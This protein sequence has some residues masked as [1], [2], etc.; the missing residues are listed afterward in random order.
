M[1]HT[2]GASI[3]DPKL[4]GLIPRITEQ[5]F[6]TIVASPST[7][8]YLVKV[9]YMEIYMVRRSPRVDPRHADAV[10]RN[11]YEICSLV[12]AA[13]WAYAGTCLTFRR[14]A[15]NDNLPIHEDKARGVYVKNLSDYYVGSANEVYEIMKQGGNARAVTSTS[16]CHRS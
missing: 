12:R 3:D 4:R 2:Q 7:L 15:Q 6:E 8:E 1:G 11:V 10:N 16:A 9:S 5:I 13:L 14:T